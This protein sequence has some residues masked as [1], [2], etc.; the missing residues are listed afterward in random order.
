M[1]YLIEVERKLFVFHHCPI[2]K[3]ININMVIKFNLFSPFQH[4]LTPLALQLI[5]TDEE[6]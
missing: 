1:K 4:G 5:K 6:C 3:N 2:E